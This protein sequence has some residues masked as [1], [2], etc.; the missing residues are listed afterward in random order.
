LVVTMQPPCPIV[1]PAVSVVFPLVVSRGRHTDFVC[2]WSSA[3]C[4]S[5]LAA[6]ALLMVMFPPPSACRLTAPVATIPF[7]HTPTAKLFLSRSEER[8]VGKECIVTL[9]QTLFSVTAPLPCT[10]RFVAGT[11]PPP[12]WSSA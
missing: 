12:A 11:D 9:L 1:P 10:R 2:D 8:R 7:A 4:S 5:H 6:I 3:V